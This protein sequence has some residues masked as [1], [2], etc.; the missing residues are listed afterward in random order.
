MELKGRILRFRYSRD[1]DG[2]TER[3]AAVYT[4]DEHNIAA[5]D[6]DRDAAYICSRLR[7]EGYETYIVGGAV[8]D[9]M[10]GN[11]PKDFDIASA[12]SPAQIKKVFRN[13]RAIGRRFRLVHVFFGNK[14]YE[15]ATFRSVKDGTDGN[16]FGSIEED[17]LRRDFSLNALFYDTEQELVIDYVG[18]V[19][20]IRK[21]IINPIIPLDA[22]FRD[23][24][25]RMIRALKYAAMTGFEIPPALRNRI[26]A[27]SRLLEAVPPSRL[28][29]EVVKILNSS[30]PDRIVAALDSFGLYQYLQPNAYRLMEKKKGFKQQYMA[31]LEAL[32]KNTDENKCALRAVIEGYVEA[33]TDWTE[34][35]PELFRKTFF[36]ARRFMIPISPQRR[37]LA[38][39]LREIF[40]EHGITVKKTRSLYDGRVFYEAGP[41][42]GDGS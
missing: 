17:V 1:K 6:V 15:L 42:A 9:L 36:S 8:R 28:T 41:R 10:L 13:S 39:A 19:E 31:S 18:G 24:P 12:A 34:A 30:C 3:K 35:M 37:E 40:A 26:K 25:V 7:V 4:K 20:D 22:I 23:D 2:K 32:A 5:G 14:I 11:K 29:E 21:R 27:D 16:T 38:A 33:N